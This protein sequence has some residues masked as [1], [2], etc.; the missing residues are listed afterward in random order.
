MT[1]EEY[2]ELILIELEKITNPEALE[3][4]LELAK[5]LQD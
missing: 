4:I 1:N 5:R 3:L 2:R